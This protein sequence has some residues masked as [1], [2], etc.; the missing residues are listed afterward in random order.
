MK[1]PKVYSQEWHYSILYTIQIIDLTLIRGMLRFMSISSKRFLLDTYIFIPC[2]IHSPYILLFLES[3]TCV[4]WPTRFSA[5]WR[6]VCGEKFQETRPLREAPWRPQERGRKKPRGIFWV[7]SWYGCWTK[8]MV[9]SP[10]ITHL[11]IGFPLFSPSILGYPYF[12]ET[13]I[14]SLD[15][16]RT[17]NQ[18]RSWFWLFGKYHLWNNWIIAMLEMDLINDTDS[19]FEFTFIGKSLWF[20]HVFPLCLRICLRI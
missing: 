13:P 2:L 20:S 8:N 14:F 16:D 4:F 15:L 12:L 18:L 17:W 3:P 19:S 10:Q 7:G 11:F 6:E 5:R 9:I 1:L